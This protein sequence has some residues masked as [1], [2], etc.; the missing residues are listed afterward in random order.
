MSLETS[1]FLDVVRFC[2]ALVVAFDHLGDYTIGVFWPIGALGPQAVDVFFVLSGYVIAYAVSNRERSFTQYAVARCARL[3]SVVLPTLIISFVLGAVGT[4]L[5]PEV[6]WG[7]TS[8]VAYFRCLLFTNQLWFSNVT[9]GY[10]GPFW[11]LG[12]EIWYYLIFAAAYFSNGFWRFA[13]T[14]LCV[15]IAGPRI[16]ML[17]PLWLMGVAAWTLPLRVN[18]SKSSATILWWSST[19][20]LAVLAVWQL[21]RISGPNPVAVV[22]AAPWRTLADWRTYLADYGIGLLVAL[23]FMSFNLAGMNWQRLTPLIIKPVRWLAGSTFTLY[24]LHVPLA[25]FLAAISPWKIGTSPQQ[26]LVEGGTFGIVLLVAEFTER[27][28]TA[29]RYAITNA[30]SLKQTQAS[31]PTERG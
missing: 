14:L 30:L 13:L 27:R 15:A 7:D 10:N 22:D 17:F 9:P 2:A 16:M 20:T 1:I 19:I 8:L 18:I 4:S 25:Q 5:R 12:Y 21:I 29:W 26:M 24:L 6:Q 3:Y 23:N 11:S 31:Y 28:K